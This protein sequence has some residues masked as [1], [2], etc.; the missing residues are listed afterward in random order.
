MSSTYRTVARRTQRYA[1]LV[2]A[3]N[4]A[5]ILWGAYVRAT[6]SGAGCGGHWPLCNGEVIPR[7]N[8]AETLIEFSHR[9]S[10]GAALLLTLGLYIRARKLHNSSRV[11]TAALA[12]GIFIIIEALIGAALVVFELVAGNTSVP[13]AIVSALHLSN[14]YFLV[15]AITLSATWSVDERKSVQPVDLSHVWGYLLGALGLLIVG[16]SGAI[17]ALGDTLFPVESLAAGVSAEF[18]TAAH[19]LVRLRVLHP[20]VAFIIGLY[21][22]LGLRLG[23]L[24]NM[25]TRGSRLGRTL[26]TLILMQW[27]AGAVNVLL[28]APV[29]MQLLHLFIADMIWI[30]FVLYTEK[31][32]YQPVD[33]EKPAR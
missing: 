12:S 6:G 19:F 7:S 16:A 20:L 22:V 13:R 29:W 1:W 10:S 9:L 32:I 21:L 14:T 18:G 30:V 5:V 25:S 33:F 15:A 31:Q 17:T 2:L 24:G 28:L 3:L 23:W 26:V 4:V 27:L 8:A 11:H